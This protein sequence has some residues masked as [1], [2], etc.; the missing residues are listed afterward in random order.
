VTLIRAFRTELENL[1][2]DGKGNV[3]G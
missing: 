3:S 1:F 2:G